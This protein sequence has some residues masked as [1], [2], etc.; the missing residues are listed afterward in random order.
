MKSSEPTKWIRVTVPSSAEAF[1]AVSNFLF[2]NGTSGLEETEDS[3]VG[4]F[5]ES[6]SI[7]ALNKL[8]QQYIQSLQRMGLDVSPPQLEIVPQEDW[9]KKWR[10]SFGPIQVTDRIR[11]WPAW[12]DDPEPEDGVTLRIMPRMA[13]GT[14]SHETTQICLE[15]LEKHVRAGQSILDVGTGSGILAIA[16]I[17]L[18][19]GRAV[20]VDI[21]SEAIENAGENA[22]LNGVPGQI[23]F[24]CDEVTSM[25]E[26][27]TDLILANINRTV[28]EKLIP[29]LTRFT[30]E[31]SIYILSGLLMSESEQMKRFLIRQQFEIIEELEKGEWT[32][33]VIRTNPSK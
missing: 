19:A 30:Y 11:I 10:E 18:G 22:R 32:G 5:P 7:D 31:N 2:E 9:S 29:Q 20:G 3:I 8:I 15:L 24:Y 25:P 26:M 23:R 33:L 4:Y 14:G 12:I 27:K 6:A 13:F 28:L 1:E 21:E 16:A 17:R